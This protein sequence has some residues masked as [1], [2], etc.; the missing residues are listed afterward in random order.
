MF[1]ILKLLYPGASPVELTLLSNF[2]VFFGC[3]ILGLG[4]FGTVMESINKKRLFYEGFPL[5]LLSVLIII[6][7]GIHSNLSITS[8]LYFNQILTSVV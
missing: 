1:D 3:L 6:V 2:S 5:I 4:L 8:F 7:M